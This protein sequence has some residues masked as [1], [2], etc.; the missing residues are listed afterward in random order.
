VLI[1]LRCIFAE[2]VWNEH[3]LDTAHLIRREDIPRLP[4]RLPRPVTADQDQLLRQEFLRRNN[5]GS[6]LFC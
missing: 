6:N 3:L 5:L 2:L 4:R 1:A